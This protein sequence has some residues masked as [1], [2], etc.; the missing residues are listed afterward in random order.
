MVAD[1]LAKRR[2]QLAAVKEGLDHEAQARRLAAAKNDL[3]GKI[4][5]FFG[6]DDHRRMVG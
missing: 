4:R 6:L 5:D 1:V 2:V 3:L